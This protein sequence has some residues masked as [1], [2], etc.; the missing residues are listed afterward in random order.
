MISALLNQFLWCS[1]RNVI[2]EPPPP[3]KISTCPNHL[4]LNTDGA[5]ALASSNGFRAALRF[6]VSQQIWAEPSRNAPGTP[7][8]LL[9]EGGGHHN[10]GNVLRGGEALMRPYNRLTKTRCSLSCR[11]CS[12]HTIDSQNFNLQ[13]PGAKEVWTRSCICMQK[14]LLYNSVYCFDTNKIEQLK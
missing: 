10:E 4:P 3:A 14:C 6:G 9:R 11:S 5:K 1:H 12:R 7:S 13:E 8:A 2:P